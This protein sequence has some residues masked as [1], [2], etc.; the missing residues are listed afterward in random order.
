MGGEGSMAAANASLKSNRSLLAKRKD[1]NALSGSYANIELKEFPKATPEQ[2]QRIKNKIQED[3]K[4]AKIKL[5][6]FSV[7]F[8]IVLL[9]LYQFLKT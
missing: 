3:N 1:K 8:I 5:F 7:G 6:Y 4:K 2:L 9:L